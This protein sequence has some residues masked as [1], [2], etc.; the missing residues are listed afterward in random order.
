[1]KNIIENE[2]LSRLFKAV[3]SASWYLANKTKNVSL[4]DKD[5]AKH[6]KSFQRALINN[7]YCKYVSKNEALKEGK[8]QH[9]VLKVALKTYMKKCEALEELTSMPTV[10]RLGALLKGGTSTKRKT[11]KKATR[12]KRV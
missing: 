10:E 7:D 5:R 6:Y 3:N 12:A 11:T 1:M 9:A 4:L 8:A 2:E